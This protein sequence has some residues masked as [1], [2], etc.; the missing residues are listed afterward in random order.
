MTW[1]EALE[2]G[3]YVDARDDQGW[4]ALVWHLSQRQ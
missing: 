4:T 3:A 2:E 1:G